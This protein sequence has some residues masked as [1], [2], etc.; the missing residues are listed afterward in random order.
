MDVVHANEPA[1]RKLRL[2]GSWVVTSAKSVS[3]EYDAYIH[4]ASGV[5]T[6]PR[7]RIPAG[8]AGCRGNRTV[9]LPPTRRRSRQ[10][11][12]DRYVGRPSGG[13]TP[14]FPSFVRRRIRPTPLTDEYHPGIA[15]RRRGLQP[16]C[17]Q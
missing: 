7:P 9:V 17:R 15:I 14:C 8:R 2:S 5:T 12:A 13:S 1:P 16:E 6:V 3:G 4:Y 10:P 11:D